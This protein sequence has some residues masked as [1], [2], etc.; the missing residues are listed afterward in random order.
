MP[1][2][3][4]DRDRWYLSALAVTVILGAYALALLSTGA[5]SD[6]GRAQ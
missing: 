1:L 5:L 6:V 2:Y 4:L 3:P